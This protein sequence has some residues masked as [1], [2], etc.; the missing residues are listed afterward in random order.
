MRFEQD[1]DLQVHFSIGGIKE[2]AVPSVP[3]APIQEGAKNTAIGRNGVVRQS[4][5]THRYHHCLQIP[6]GQRI[7]W[8]LDIQMFG[9]AVDMTAICGDGGFRQ[10]LCGLGNNKVVEHFFYGFAGLSR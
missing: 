7:H 6:F 5:L 2:G 8:L 1:N 10:S 9:D 3:L 4:C